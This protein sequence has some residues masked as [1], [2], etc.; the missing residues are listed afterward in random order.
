MLELMLVRHA[1]TRLNEEHRYQGRIDPP[2]SEWGREEAARLGIRL[3]GARFDH[4]LIADSRRCAETAAIALPGRSFAR[5]ARLRELHFGR[6]EG[7]SYEECLAMDAEPLQAWIDQPTRN[8]PPGGEAFGDFSR[9]VDAAMDALPA[10]GRAL[11]IAHAGPIR[12]VLTRAV[13]LEWSQ[14]VLFQLSPAGITHLA[15]HPEGGHLRSLN[16]TAHL[17]VD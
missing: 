15:L 14:V 17:V 8:A 10:A 4:L 13:G 16:D 11:V 2:L 5:D 12:R 1:S 3:H 7:L 9:R 6:W